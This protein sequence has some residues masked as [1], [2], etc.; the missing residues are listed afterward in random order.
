MGGGAN[1]VRTL[2][3]NSVTN[4]EY[5]E[6]GGKD[7]S[8][9]RVLSSEVPRLQSS[10]VCLRSWPFG[11]LGV[12]VDEGSEASSGPPGLHRTES[13]KDTG[14]QNSWNCSSR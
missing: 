5:S 4:G 1:V 2:V 6:D 3:V 9:R 7:R 14:G 11:E 12:E 13:K 8:G 10:K